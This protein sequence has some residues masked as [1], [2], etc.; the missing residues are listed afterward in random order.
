MSKA[1]KIIGLLIIV[2]IVIRL[3]FYIPVL[4][5]LIL[6]LTLILSTIYFFLGFALL[7]NVR[8]RNITKSASY[9]NFTA[10]RIIGAVFTGFVLSLI[11]LYC[12]FK[13]MRWPFANQGLII[14]L[15]TLIIPISISGL[16]FFTSKNRFYL[17]FLLRL[18][19][20]AIIG[21]VFYITPSQTILELKNRN[22]PEYIEAEKKL[23]ND[24]NNE[25]LQQKV[26]E[27]RKKKNSSS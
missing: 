6:L 9:K 25:E 8:F 23:M 10:L 21:S 1:E 26:I 7:N 24:P 20:F 22:I 27:E 12:L 15:I 4:N 3:L 2:L 17:N 14:A 19:I 5:T 16:K 18:V 13:F 11:C